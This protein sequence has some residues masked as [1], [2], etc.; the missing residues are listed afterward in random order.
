MSTHSSARN[1]FPRLDNLELTIQRRPRVDLTLLNDFDI[2]T[3]GNGDDVPP[4]EGGDLPVPDLRTMKELCQPTLNGRGGTF[5]KRCPEEC[6]DLIENMTAHHNDWD[7]F[8]QITTV[9]QTQNVYVAGAYNQG[10]NSY[11][12]QGNRNFHSYRLDNYLGPPGGTTKEETNSSK[13]LVMV[14]TPASIL[15][16]TGL[17]NPGLPRSGSAGPD[18]LTMTTVSFSGSGTLPS[19]TNTNPKEDFKGI[20]T[21][22]GIAYQGPTIPTTSS[23]PKVV[24][25]ETDVTKDTVPPTNNGS[26][27]NVQPPVVQVKTQIPNYEPVVAPIVEP[28][29]AAVSAPKP[30]PIPSIPYP[31]MD[32]LI[33]MPKFG[34]N[35][36]SLLTN[37]DKLFELAR[38]PLNEYWSAVL[39]KKLPEK[40]VDPG[41]F[42]I[43]CDFPGLDECLAL[44]DLVKIGR[45]LIDVYEGELTLRVG[46]EAVTFNL[47]QTLRYFA[48][49]DAMSVNR[50]DLIDVACEEYS[51]EG[52]D[53]LPVINAKDLKDEE[54]T[55]LIKVL[56]S[57]KQALAWKL[58]DI[59]GIDPKFCTYKILMEDDFKLAVQ[60]QR[61]VNQNIHEVIKKEDM[62]EKTMEVIMDDFLIFRNS[63][64][65]CLSH[66]DKML[67]RCE[68]T[69]L[70][71]NWKKIDF[72][73]KEG[74][75]LGHKISMKGIEEIN[76]TFPLETLNVV[77]FHGDSST[78]WFSDFA[79][80]HAGNFVVKGISSQQK[81]KFFK[82]VKHYFWDDPFLFK[83]FADQVIR[84]CDHGQEAVDILKVCHNGPTGGYHGLNY[85]AKKVF[86]FDFR[87]LGIDFMRPFPSSRGNK[88]ILMAVDYLSKTVE[89]KALPTN[90]DRVVC[91]ILKSLFSRF[92]T[93]RAI[94]SDCGTHFCNDQLT[95]VMLKYDVIHRLATAYHL[96]TSGQVEVS[97][98]GL[99]ESW[100]GP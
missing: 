11:Q 95:K 8:V 98:R 43:P 81:K 22:S 76:E 75:V 37:K 33:L 14:K 78:L 69:N 9:V 34:P 1:L 17:S 87:R 19:N 44:A 42:L 27:Q 7:T 59:K 39:L 36:K 12:P 24:E 79:N 10:D 82:D 46:K 31:F 84:Q 6:Y 67:K 100:K 3:N 99:K 62:I 40:L 96:Q 64:G 80:Y 77:S 2:A 94:I 4:P 61:R 83:I 53:K 30:N 60:H 5:M 29:E 56:K 97:N 66:L 93:P 48:N 32:A 92:G 91:K 58:F 38:T 57:H 41:K 50:I 51:Q 90:D 15:S 74:I 25:R 49:Y 86:D 47:D 55:T 21:R 71:L 20:T 26:T 54:K 68:D 85:T 35:I 18:S 52:D 23:L 28:V 65:T 88:Y 72:M 73:V 45:T 13:E 70:F 63:F 16:S 89:A